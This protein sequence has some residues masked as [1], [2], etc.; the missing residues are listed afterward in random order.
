LLA[1]LGAPAGDVWRDV[2]KPAMH[3]Q[4]LGHAQIGAPVDVDIG[5]FQ[6]F[7]AALTIQH[8]DQGVH[9]GWPAVFAQLA[10]GGD[11]KGLADFI[12]GN[13]VGTAQH[14]HG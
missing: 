12:E 4:L 8:H 2:A 11:Q 10:T 5:V 14:L 6:L 1:G 7:I 13:A 3:E 9:P